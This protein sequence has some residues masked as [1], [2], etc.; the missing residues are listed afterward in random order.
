[1]PWLS[2]TFKVRPNYV[3]L[4]SDQLLEQGALSIDVHDAGEGTDQ[5]QP[6]FGEPGSPAEQIWLQTEIT[7]LL[8]ESAD[9]DEIVQTI[10]EV[11]GSS[12][13]PE[14]QLAHVAEQDW[15]RLTQSQFDPIEIS[16]RLWIVPSWH[17]LPDP[18]AINLRLDP[19]LAFGTG[20]H[21]T[22]R[23]CLTWLD[24]FIQSSD[25]V[26]DYGCGSGIL[27]IAALKLGAQRVMGVDIDPNAITA[28]L[29]NARNNQC[30]SA[31]LLFTTALSSLD[32]DE[33]TAEWLPATVVVAN[34][35]TNPLIMLAPIL[36][37]AVQTGGRIVLSGILTEQED[38]VLQVY[39]EWFDMQV[40]ARDQG[41]VLL[42]GQKI[43]RNKT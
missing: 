30:D 8:E 6:L 33:A 41:W 32:T 28:S 5:E 42:V 22:T 24:Q 21:P 35:L 9:I 15:V 2:L 18:S 20:S 17:T 10:A 39:S 19:G 4:V 37:H 43:A 40:V 25:R 3:D 38:E 29:E 27:A 36:M 13:L 7:A 11:T 31:R 26:F 12:A 16:P 1:M 34:I 14:Y 23:L